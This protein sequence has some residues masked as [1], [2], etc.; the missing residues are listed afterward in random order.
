MFLI[1]IQKSSLK[2]MWCNFNKLK[3]IHCNNQWLIIPYK[4]VEICHKNPTVKSRTLFEL[5]NLYYTSFSLIHG[6]LRRNEKPNQGA[7]DDKRACFNLS[8]L[9]HYMA[10]RMSGAV[11]RTFMSYFTPYV[12]MAFTYDA[13]WTLT[14]TMYRYNPYNL[15]RTTTC[16]V[17]IPDT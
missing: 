11:T 9:G 7:C 17:A 2:C 12:V 1:S 6:T 13:S 3:M 16:L 10:H 15:N 8:R 14:G 5:A 4:T